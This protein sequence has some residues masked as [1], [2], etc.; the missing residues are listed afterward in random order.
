MSTPRWPPSP[1]TSTITDGSFAKLQDAMAALP[2]TGGVATPTYAPVM[3]LGRLEILAGM[4]L[5]LLRR[6]SPQG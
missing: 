4:G 6:R 3:A 1:Y 2:E 5:A